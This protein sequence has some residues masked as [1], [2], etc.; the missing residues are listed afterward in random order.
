MLKKIQFFY[1]MEVNW[2][3]DNTEKIYKR[4]SELSNIEI[5]NND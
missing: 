2:Y 5:I 1:I 3:I 4:F